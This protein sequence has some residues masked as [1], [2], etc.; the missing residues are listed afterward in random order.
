MSD[1]EA[2][3]TCIQENVEDVEGCITNFFLG[4]FGRSK[5]VDHNEYGGNPYVQDSKLYGQDYNQIK[6]TPEA[7]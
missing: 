2:S 6:V 3:E 1:I 5:F 4:L 7:S